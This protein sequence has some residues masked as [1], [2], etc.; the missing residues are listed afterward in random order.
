MRRR[1]RE[2]EKA[3]KSREVAERKLSDLRSE[4]GRMT[5]QQATL[6]DA[7]RTKQERYEQKRLEGE[8]ELLALRKQSDEYSKR[9]RALEQANARQQQMLSRQT[10]AMQ[11]QSHRLRTREGTGREGN[12]ATRQPPRRPEAMTPN[13]QHNG[14]HG[15]GRKESAAAGG[16]SGTPVAASKAR[17]ADADVEGGRPSLIPSPAKAAHAEAREAREAREAT[18][19]TEAAAEQAALEE[20]LLRRKE[21]AE[22]LG[23]EL[24]RREAVLAEQEA[25]VASREALQLRQL[26]TSIS[27]R[28]SIDSLSQRLV[29]L[30]GEIA[31]ARDAAARDAAAREGRREEQERP[32]T[33]GGGDE[34]VRLL[35]ERREAQERLAEL[36]TLGA[37]GAQDGA[38]LLDAAAQSEL[39]ALEERLEDLTATLE[40]RNSAIGELRNSLNRESIGQL[41]DGLGG[42]RLLPEG[43]M[44]G[45]SPFDEHLEERLAHMSAPVARRVLAANLNRL[46]ELRHEQKAAQR[47]LESAELQ[48]QER[49]SALVTAQAALRQA[50]AEGERRLEQAHGRHVRELIEQQ[51]IVQ[52]L[53]AKLK[54]A[55]GAANA[56]QAVSQE[57]SPAATGG[58]C[59]DLSPG[60]SSTSHTPGGRTPPGHTSSNVQTPDSAASAR[61][62]S[63][64]TLEALGKDNF[65][66]K[67]ANRELRKKLRDAA[68][69]TD[70]QQQQL[71]AA[72][73]QAADDQ[74]LQAQLHAELAN[75]KAYLAAHPGAT[76]TRVTKAALKEIG[77]MGRDAPA[78]AR[79][80]WTPIS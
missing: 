47:Q 6:R 10:E 75:L 26:R 73:Q 80:A 38:A 50:S 59:A 8:R 29:E 63:Q 11:Q 43:A 7:M 24:A 70:A 79:A 53:Q 28:T 2:Q 31:A 62:P 42:G 41:G 40:F 34:L 58:A 12:R 9:V 21:A 39:R 13:G 45:A 69:A 72:R 14:P 78:P 51:R 68:G 66:Y 74:Q 15:H 27:L 60:R 18:E 4:V 17:K 65:Y 1:Q 35:T 54:S 56:S 46:L 57:Q 33:G 19:A 77:A 64:Q 22:A 5:S 25:V 71:D 55:R 44:A 67:Q 76:P 23:V 20:S 49:E 52:D 61:S 37:A 48:A 3:L 36:E 32:G 30:D 16:G